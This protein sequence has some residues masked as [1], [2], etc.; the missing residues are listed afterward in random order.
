MEQVIKPTDLRINN[1]VYCKYR[2]GHFLVKEITETWLRIAEP[3]TGY[4][5]AESYETVVPIDLSP[6]ILEAC[7]F[8]KD[9]FKAYNLSIS[10]WPDTHLKQLSFAGDYLYLREGGIEKNR[11][12]DSLCVLWNNDLRGKMQLHQ[13][14]NLVQALTGTELS[15]NL[16]KVKV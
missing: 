5:Y 3:E 1:A 12:A 15:I 4:L 9:G 8:E 7:G 13:L 2:Q 14:Q 6:D 10:P 16:E 11:T